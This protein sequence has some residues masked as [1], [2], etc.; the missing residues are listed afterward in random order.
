MAHCYGHCCR[1]SPVRYLVTLRVLKQVSMRVNYINV[2]SH[3]IQKRYC[4]QCLAY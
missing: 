3:L 2:T 1:E 4:I